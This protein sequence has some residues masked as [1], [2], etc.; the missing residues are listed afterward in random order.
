MSLFLPLNSRVGAS[1]PAAISAGSST[2]T[3]A[4]TVSFGLGGLS[5]GSSSSEATL[6]RDLKLAGESDGLSTSPASL[7]INDEPNILMDGVSAGA[8]TSSASV[9]SGSGLVGISTGASSSSGDLDVAAVPDLTFTFFVDITSETLTS[10]LSNNL[11]SYSCGLVVDGEPVPI[12]SARLD[13]PADRLGTEL[14]VILAEPDAALVTASSLVDFLLMVKTSAG[15]ESITILEGARL[16]GQ[17]ARYANE[18]GLPADSVEISLIDVMADRWNRAPR[19]PITLYDPS[20]IDPPS[21]E[22]ISSE[23]IYTSGG[24]RLVP[25]YQAISGLSLFSIFEAA[26]VD[27]CGFDHVISNIDD[28]PVEMAVFSLTGGYDQAV[29]P[30]I[31]SFEPII[32]VQ[33]NDLWIV[34]LDNPLPAGFDARTLPIS[35]IG[36]IDDQLPRRELI[37]GLLVTVKDS[38]SGEYFTERLETNSTTQGVFGSGEETHTDIERRVREYR[39]IAAPTIIKREEEAYLETRVLDAAFNEISIDVVE[40]HLDALNR[41]TGHHRTQHS[42]LPNPAGELELQLS[43]DETQ[44]ITYGQ[45]PLY[46][47]RDIQET[48]T[49]EQSGLILIDNDQQYLGEPYRIPLHNAHEAG[50]VDPDADQETRFG[51]LRTVIEQ[52]RVNGGQVER[53]RRVINH[54]SKVQEP[55][56]TQVI[57]G[58]AS[59][60]RRQGARTRTV[61][62]TTPGSDPESR[63]VQPFDGTG[64]PTETA[65]RLAALRLARLSSPPKEAQ[66]ELAYLEPSLLRR[67]VDLQVPARTGSLGVYI[68]RS[69]SASFTLTDDGFVAEMSLGAKELQQ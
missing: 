41:P 31:E 48:I 7:R 11:R 30:L 58:D 60:D 37:N 27:G 40:H 24:A 1:P 8:S 43:L 12:L 34:T 4:L 59:F 38:A 17:G 63:R 2:S 64:L 19:S 45:H 18:S 49:T 52:I 5:A 46:P 62:I 66:I 22:Q 15:W 36:G 13:A 54:V 3:G 56:T 16:G 14:T 67:G 47:Q 61:L 23:T 9:Q 39:D 51:K 53:D 26:Y 33:A 10:A 68:V 21:A 25:E 20:V 65:M 42:L 69:Y 55:A 6:A 35:V 44:L 29:R 50:Y 32:F 57:P 28:F